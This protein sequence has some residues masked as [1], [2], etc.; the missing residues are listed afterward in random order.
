MFVVGAAIQR[1]VT[2]RARSSEGAWAILDGF[3]VE[4]RRRCGWMCPQ[5]MEEGMG[6]DLKHLFTSS[7]SLGSCGC[8]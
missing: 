4:E 2:G 1:H 6:D 8:C 7:S 5:V 3:E